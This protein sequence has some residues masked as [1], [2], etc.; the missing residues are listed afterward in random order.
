MWNMNICNN[1]HVQ[2]DSFELDMDNGNI[3]S[4]NDIVRKSFQKYGDEYK[5]KRKTWISAEGENEYYY[6]YEYALAPGS[7]TNYYLTSQ[8]WIDK[9]EGEEIIKSETKYLQYKDDK[10]DLIY[11]EIKLQAD[12]SRSMSINNYGVSL[13]PKR[14]T[15]GQ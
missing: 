12:T 10:G 6:E 3:I 8:K 15:R 13:M 11:E 5:L 14:Y 9:F 4:I 1:N 2:Q 7:E